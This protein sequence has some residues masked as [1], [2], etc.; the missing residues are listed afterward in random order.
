MHGSPVRPS[1]ARQK[2]SFLYARRSFGS[3]T[4]TPPTPPSFERHGERSRL[5]RALPGCRPHARRA[6]M[7]G[8]LCPF[9]CGIVM[10]FEEQTALLG[11]KGP[12]VNTWRPAGIGGGMELNAAVAL[13]VVTYDQIAFG[14]VHLFPMVM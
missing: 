10:K 9:S 1:M 4:E 14:Q 2:S 13:R 11:F 5:R 3:H 12:M 8:N 6:A 7:P